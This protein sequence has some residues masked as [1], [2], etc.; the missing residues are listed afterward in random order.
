MLAREAAAEEAA[1]L[2][3]RRNGNRSGGLGFVDRRAGE[4]FGGRLLHRG[5]NTGLASRYERLKPDSEVTLTLQLE[6]SDWMYSSFSQMRISYWIMTGLVEGSD[7][8]SMSKM[9]MSKKADCVVLWK[10][11][12]GMRTR[13]GSFAEREEETLLV[14]LLR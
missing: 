12:K 8:E 1:L 7:V 10:T 13:K 3:G 9:H 14:E 4:R 6:A 2:A 11:G 5:K